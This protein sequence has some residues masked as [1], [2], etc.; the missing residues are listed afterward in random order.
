VPAEQFW[1]EERDGDEE[2]DFSSVNRM[3]TNQQRTEGGIAMIIV[4]IVIVILAVLAG[5]FA[6]SM[7]VETKLA[8]N[9]SF[10]SEMELLGRS[11]VEKA[12]YVLAMQRL[13][14]EQ[15]RYTALN[16][17]WANGPA[18]TNELLMDIQMEHCALTQGEYSIHM[19]DMERKFSLGAIREGNSIILDRALELIGVDAADVSTIVDSYLDWTDVDETPRLHGAESKFYLHFNPQAPYYAKNGPMDD[20]SELLLI[21]GM[22]P[23]IYWGSGRT[24]MIPGGDRVASR[25]TVMVDGSDEKISVGLYDLFTTISAA[26]MKININTASAEVLQL[27][28]GMTPSLARSIVET[29]QGPDHEDGTEDDVPFEQSQDV[30]FVGGMDPNVMQAL[31]AFATL[32]SSVFKV[33]VDAKIGNFT[34]QYEAMLQVRPGNLEV[35]ILYFRWL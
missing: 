6:Y 24:G 21:Q 30:A 17:K 1:S 34:R 20:V 12:R 35:T 8:R 7:K 26:G 22:T 15:A 9:S 3:K 4:M 5:G 16:Q 23:E 33:T 13:A 11:G 10:E 27:I 2:F 14:P 32:Q 19:E 25:S 31:Q 28:P 29:R 18:G